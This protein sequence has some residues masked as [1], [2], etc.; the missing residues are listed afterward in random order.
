MRDPSTTLALS[1]LC[2]RTISTPVPPIK[3]QAAA[4]GSLVFGDNLEARLV[5]LA[6]LRTNT[7]PTEL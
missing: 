6:V 1:K 3:R 4:P 7:P 5:T 2:G